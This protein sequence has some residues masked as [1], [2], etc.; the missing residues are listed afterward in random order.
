MRISPYEIAQEMNVSHVHVYRWIKSGKIK[1]TLNHSGGNGRNPSYT[2]MREDFEEFKKIRDAINAARSD[3][4]M[5]T[6]AAS[7]R[8][9][10]KY[11]EIFGKLPPE[12]RAFRN[13]LI[14][15]RDV[16]RQTRSR[17]ESA[18]ELLELN[19]RLTTQ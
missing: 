14:D 19:D 5:E 2:V 8:W 7:K 3:K 4:M 9:F 16:R 12:Y 15:M 6:D 10:A 18:M 1:S 13:G 17:L 11:Y